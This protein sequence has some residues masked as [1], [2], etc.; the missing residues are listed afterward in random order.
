MQSTFVSVHSRRKAEEEVKYVAWRNGHSVQI[1]NVSQSAL[2]VKQVQRRDISLLLLILCNAGSACTL[3]Y[4]SLCPVL[5]A[6]SCHTKGRLSLPLSLVCTDMS[7]MRGVVCK[8]CI[9]FSLLN[10][11]RDS[12]NVTSDA[13]TKHKRHPSKRICRIKELMVKNAD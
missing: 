13:N 2:I 3:L 7:R 9:T 11:A 8:C 10:S 12:L 5:S 1:K 6:I 4:G